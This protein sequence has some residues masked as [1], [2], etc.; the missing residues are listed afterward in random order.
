VLVSDLTEADLVS[1]IQALVP[2]SPPWLTVGIGDDAAVVE[3]V[4]N[5]LEVLSV[6]ALVEGV[7]FDR[8]FT[9]PDAIGH[10]A[11]AVNLSDLGAMGAEPRLA[12]L[13][14]VL[15]A[16]LPVADFESMIQGFGALA[17]RHRVCV[18]G[19]NL[20]RSPGPLI[21]DVT[22][23]G[24]VKR[25]Q[26]LRRQGAR[27][28]DLVF[29]TGSIGGAAAG[30]QMLGSA[31]PASDSCARRYLYPS[32]RV[33][34]GVLLARNRAASACIDLSD[35]LA[36]AVHQVAAASGVGIRIDAGALPVHGDARR[37]FEARGEDAVE[38]AICSSDD[39]ELLFTSRPRWAGRIRNA[40][41]SS[42]APPTQIG[43][44]TP[45]LEVVLDRGGDS[46]AMSFGYKH[47]G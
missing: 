7:H 22:V 28:G 13:S 16:A 47:F 4:S 45:G 30:L 43:V 10:R 17:A 1:R 9:P 12:L 34:T 23:S 24:V 37:W 46:S 11:L 19:G 42:E 39:Y 44:C 36:D 38:R 35:G 3:P 27:P 8:R 41:R 20:A 25:R 15:P 26:L 18:V 21:L 6:D 14:L 31:G 40:L 5:R 33:R 2:P 29:V 32:P